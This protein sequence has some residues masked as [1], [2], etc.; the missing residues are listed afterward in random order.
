MDTRC[1]NWDAIVSQQPWWNLSNLSWRNKSLE[2]TTFLVSEQGAEIGRPSR[3][4]VE[5]ESKDQQIDAVRV[6]GQVVPVAKGI[7]RF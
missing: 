3:L 6:G 7:V 1:S 2:P 5:V 4:Y